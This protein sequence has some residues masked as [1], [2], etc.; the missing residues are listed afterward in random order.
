MKIQIV[1]KAQ[2]KA[3]PNGCTFIIEDLLQPQ[4]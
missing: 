3:A 4:K 1:K 2:K